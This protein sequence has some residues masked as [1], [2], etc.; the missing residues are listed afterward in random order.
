MGLVPPFLGV[1]PIQ[2]AVAKHGVDLEDRHHLRVGVLKEVCR[3]ILN[4]VLG[5]AGQLLLLL[6]CANQEGLVLPDEVAHEREDGHQDDGKQF[7]RRVHVAQDPVQH[8]QLR[9]L[10]AHSSAC[11]TMKMINTPKMP[12][13]RNTPTTCAIS[14][15]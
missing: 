10:F 4:P 8:R 15:L 5:D 7:E 1:G 6:V 12:R 14:S 9:F 11:F 3:R 13:V 2:H